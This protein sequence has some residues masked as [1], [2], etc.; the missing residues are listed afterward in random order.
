MSIVQCRALPRPGPCVP[1][2]AQDWSNRDAISAK[3][4]IAL[5]EDHILN[6]HTPRM[7]VC[8][9]VAKYSS[10]QDL[11]RFP[12]SKA[13]RCIGYMIC[14]GKLCFKSTT[15]VNRVKWHLFTSACSE[16]SRLLISILCQCSWSKNNHFWSFPLLDAL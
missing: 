2:C 6:Q 11:L 5:W 13:S 3:R 14:L 15:R 8:M 9:Y 12:Y 1:S 7:Y 10:S 16:Q 4:T